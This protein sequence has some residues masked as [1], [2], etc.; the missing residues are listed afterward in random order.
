MRYVKA[1]YAQ[2]LPMG[3][4][5]GYVMDGDSEWVIERL[6]EALIQRAEALCLVEPPVKLSSVEG[7]RRFRT[8]HRRVRDLS[9]FEVRHGL[10]PLSPKGVSR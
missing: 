1:Q 5:L 8:V 4:M 3:A 7:I 6:E 10:L 2:R 9:L